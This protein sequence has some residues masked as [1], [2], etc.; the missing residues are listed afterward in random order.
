MSA[1][2]QGIELGSRLAS[3]ARSA[4]DYG[5]QAVM[6]PTW[7]RSNSAPPMMSARTRSINVFYFPGTAGQRSPVPVMVV[8]DWR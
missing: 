5:H 4:L 6:P 1:A 3:E 7:R 2:S 8:G